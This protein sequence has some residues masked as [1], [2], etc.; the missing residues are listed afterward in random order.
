MRIGC[1]LFAA[2]VGSLITLINARYGFKTADNEFEGYCIAILFAAI[3]VA[4]LAGHSVALRLWKTNKGVSV[5]IGLAC[6]IALLI[7]LS[8]SLSAMAGRGDAAQAQ[9][10]KTAEEVRDL[11]RSLKD[12]QE[13]R[14]SLK[15][16]PADEATVAAAKKASEAAVDARAKECV[17]RGDNCR[18]REA[19]EGKALAALA[20][21]SANKAATDR[22]K[23][24]DDS[25]AATRKALSQSGPVLAPNAQGTALASL[26][27]LPDS[28]ASFL[29]TWQS[30]AIGA[31]AE[32][33]V[34]TAMIA[35]EAL[36][37]QGSEMTPKPK[38]RREEPMGIEPEA[39]PFPALELA[40]KPRLVTSRSDPAGNVAAI[41]AEVMEPGKA[42]DKTEIADLFKAYAQACRE[43]GKRP[44]PPE[45]FSG[46]VQRLCGEL[47]IKVTHRGEHV[48]LTK[49]RLKEIE[50]S[51]G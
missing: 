18:Q 15:F 25:I 22:A 51:A 21:A 49:V 8:N 45:D 14:A 33:L 12:A 5:L 4:A 32:I 26:F 35:A 46:A 9:R 19:D 23:T 50:A 20:A 24:L 28:W 7:S 27:S 31:V 38:G 1:L 47:G 6:T 13:E 36:R 37:G 40:P 39:Q 48:Y 17:K 42:R 3:S 2:I 10:I 16:T 44:V 11:R 41:M 43:Q 29:S 30:F 34:A